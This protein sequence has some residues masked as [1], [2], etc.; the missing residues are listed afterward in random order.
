MIKKNYSLCSSL[1]IFVMIKVLV[2]V[3]PQLSTDF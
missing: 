1:V 3:F 2:I